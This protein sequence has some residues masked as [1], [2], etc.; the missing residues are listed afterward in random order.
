MLQSSVL[1]SLLLQLD[2]VLALQTLCAAL[3]ARAP[4][5]PAH[6][7]QFSDKKALPLSD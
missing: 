5:G 3:L 6:K 2:K 4:Q 1:S 7:L